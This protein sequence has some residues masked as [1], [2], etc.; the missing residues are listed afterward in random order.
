MPSTSGT[1]TPGPLHPS[2]KITMRTFTPSSPG[3]AW[4]SV[5][6]TRLACSCLQH[7]LG[8]ADKDPSHV[9]AGRSTSRCCRPATRTAWP[10]GDTPKARS[11]WMRARSDLSL[12]SMSLGSLSHGLPSSRGEARAACVCLCHGVGICAF[13]WLWH[14]LVTRGW[15]PSVPARRW[16]PGARSRTTLLLKRCACAPDCHG[17]GRGAALPASHVVPPRQVWEGSYSCPE[18]QTQTAG[19]AGRS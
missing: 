19:S 3:D 15:A 2:T 8:T 7:V 12:R 4:A 5:E 1:V 14:L 6:A 18:T 10:R 9:P 11:K 17:S 16:A 13:C